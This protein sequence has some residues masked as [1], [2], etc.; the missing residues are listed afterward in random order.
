MNVST[1]PHFYSALSRKFQG[2][3]PY[4]SGWEDV[5]LSQL[6]D[7]EAFLEEGLADFQVM[8][9]QDKVDY[10]PASSFVFNI[11]QTLKTFLQ[12]TDQLPVKYLNPKSDGDAK[13]RT[14]R[15]IILKIAFLWIPWLDS[16]YEPLIKDGKY[17]YQ[18]LPLEQVIEKGK[19]ERH[20]K[21]ADK[22]RK[23]IFGVILGSN[24]QEKERIF[25]VL[26]KLVNG[27]GGVELAPYL[28]AAKELNLISNKPPF[29]AM[30]M[31]WGVTNTS[32]ALS[33]YMTDNYC[34]IDD[35]IIE[36]RRKEIRRALDAIS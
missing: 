36:V 9:M 32:A 34:G 23:C 14:L 13:A 25:N 17:E 33:R 27:L 2:L 16:D 30:E 15:E 31:F 1:I 26:K 20:E 28:Q 7:I 22:Y 24:P 18:V 19:A 29:P 6:Q 5:E 35:N 21:I 8:V 4:L 10:Y 3:D 11:R 12:W